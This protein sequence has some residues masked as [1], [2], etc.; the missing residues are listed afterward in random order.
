[1]TRR[2]FTMVEL[3]IY[4][5]IIGFV[6]VIYTSFTADVFKSA[7]RSRIAESVQENTQ[8]V[9]NQ[10]A[11]DVRTARSITVSDP[12]A[13]DDILTITKSGGGAI[14]YTRVGTSINREEPPSASVPQ[15]PD[16]VLLNLNYYDPVPPPNPLIKVFKLAGFGVNVVLVTKYK[17]DTKELTLS[18]TIYPRQQLY[19]Q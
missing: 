9:M 14:I 5:T 8:L 4:M 2:G 12:T 7:Q 13:A 17:D 6:G 10:I 11:Q 18:S 1:M 16:Q 19:R 15:L 3:I